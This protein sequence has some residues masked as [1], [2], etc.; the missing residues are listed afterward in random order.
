MLGIFGSEQGGEDLPSR[1]FAENDSE[2]PECRPH[3][4]EL[5]YE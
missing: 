3:G 1:H 2:D 5:A 4:E